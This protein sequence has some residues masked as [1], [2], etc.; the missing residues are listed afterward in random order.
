[1][2][3]VVRDAAE[4]QGAAVSNCRSESKSVAEAAANYKVGS[5]ETAAPWRALSHERH[6]IRLG[7]PGLE[8]G[9]NPDKV[10]AAPLIIPIVRIQALSPGFSFFLAVF[11]MRGPPALRELAEKRPALADPLVG[12][13]CGNCR[14]DVR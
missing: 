10:G 7:R 2:I 9:T 12:T 11:P 6:K 1:M 5:L 8:P 4:K 14:A 13:S 3:R